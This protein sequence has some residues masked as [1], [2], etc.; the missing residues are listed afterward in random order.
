MAAREGRSNPT[1]ERPTAADVV[2]QAGIGALERALRFQVD[3]VLV[4][5]A[6][7]LHPDVDHPAPAGRAAGGGALHGKSL[8]PRAG[9][10]RRAP[11]RSAA[12]RTSGSLP[13]GLPGGAVRPAR[14]CRAAWHPDRHSVAAPDPTVPAH[15][16][17]FVGSGF[18]SRIDWLAAMDWTGIDLGLY[19]TWQNVGRRHPLAAL[20][21]IRASSTT[22]SAIALSRRAKVGIES[23]PRRRRGDGGPLLASL[24]ES[25]NPRAVR[26]RGVRRSFI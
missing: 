6:M 12:G 8:R 3:A 25:L 21:A 15:D 10:R 22:R 16:V 1:I 4:V 14:I 26:A 7:L 5:S 23:L 17:V 11:G 19:G 2:Y 9:T 18:P 13:A 24:G 20:R